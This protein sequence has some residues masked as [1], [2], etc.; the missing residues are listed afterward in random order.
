M[1]SGL[2]VP[3]LHLNPQELSTQF[4]FW[5]K[6]LLVWYA[7]NHRNLP[8]RKTPEPYSIW[9]S[10]V[11]LQQTQVK[12]VIAYHDRF[13][14]RFPT[15]QSLARADQQDVLKL[16]EGLG[17]YSRA[18]NFHKAAIQVCSRHSGQIPADWNAFRQLPGVGDYIASAVLS[19][20]FN[21]PFAVVDGNVKRVI[22]R[23]FAMNTP[24]NASRAHS[25]FQEPATALLD[26]DAPG[27]FNQ[28][29]MELGALICKPKKPLCT[30]CPLDACCVA[31]ASGQVDVYPKRVKV[32]PV[33]L[34]PVVA[35]VVY[36]RGRML[37][38]QR[39]PDGLLGGLWEFPGGKIQEGESPSDACVREIREETGVSARI[40]SHLC[41][42]KHA[43]THFKIQ[44]QVFICHA[45]SG[46]VRLNGPVDFRWITADDMDLYP[47]PGA[48][49]KFLGLLK[50]TEHTHYKTSPTG[51]K[52]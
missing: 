3:P 46:A 9:V 8:W 45:L 35:G 7:E 24:V 27:I 25:V 33:P 23:L 36:H 11:M 12:T 30:L 14:K 17:Y 16:W 21:Q 5:R 4:I 19:I 28:A 18:R 26:H 34:Y 39:K 37:I 13:L 48:N 20:A 40:V 41:Q 49:H 44:M 10:E 22:S 32:P 6:R 15:I 1:G 38:T 52:K 29:M 51:T 31:F 47:F 43:Y 50:N 42:V 2:S